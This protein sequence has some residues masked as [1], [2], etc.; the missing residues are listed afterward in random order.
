MHCAGFHHLHLHTGCRFD[1]ALHMN[2]HLNQ[3]HRDIQRMVEHLNQSF[4]KTHTQSVDNPVCRWMDRWVFLL[5][6]IYLGWILVV[7]GRFVGCVHHKKNC[8]K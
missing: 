3:M 1:L 4:E 8:E 7:V 6:A 2:Q 5:T